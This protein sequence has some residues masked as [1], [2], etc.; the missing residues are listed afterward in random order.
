M[1]VREGKMSYLEKAKARP[2]QVKKV[3]QTVQQ[4]GVAAA[5]GKVMN[6][7][8]SLT[9]LGYSLSGEITAVGEEAA[10][11]VA[12]DRVACAGVGY[13][14]HAEINFVPRTLVVAVPHAVRMEHAAFATLGAIA[15]QGLRRSDMQLGETACVI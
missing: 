5:Y 8:D 3:L 1:K 9:P 12:G 14:N 13:A 15:L 6:K 2:D 4:Q 7:L 11:F 10:D